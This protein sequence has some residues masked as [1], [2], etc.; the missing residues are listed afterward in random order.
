MTEQFVLTHQVRKVS[1]AVV[2]AGLATAFRVER[3]EV[4]PKPGV[5]QVDPAT[6]GEGRAVAGEAGWQDAVEH[7]H[8][9]GNHLEDTHRIPDAHEVARL[10]R[11]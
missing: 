9:E 7:V 2:C 11:G 3:S 8:A 10:L 6:G 1:P 5:P 4:A